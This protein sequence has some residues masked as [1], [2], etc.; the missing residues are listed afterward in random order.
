MAADTVWLPLHAV[1]WL[2]INVQVPSG[3]WDKAPVCRGG[4][5]NEVEFSPRRGPSKGSA[6]G[7]SGEA[8][9]W[10]AARSLDRETSSEAKVA[11]WPVRPRKSRIVVSGRGASVYLGFLHLERI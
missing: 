2:A 4:V 9:M 8:E 3:G 7:A 6:E 5:S 11:L 10:R 1:E